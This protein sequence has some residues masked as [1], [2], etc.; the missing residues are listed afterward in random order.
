MS[1]SEWDA[2]AEMGGLIITLATIGAGVAFA[3]LRTRFVT[4][5]EHGRSHGALTVRIDNVENSLDGKVN[6][7]DL[8]ALNDRLYA[9]EQSLS[10]TK[11]QLSETNALLRANT[12][13]SRALERQIM[14][15]IENELRAEKT[16]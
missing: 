10:Q 4:R 14:M 2:V 3:V 12:D 7:E 9:C 8:R 16:R 11:S 1:P 13:A 6:K 5:A 15:L